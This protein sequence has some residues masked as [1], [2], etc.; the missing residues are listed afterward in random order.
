[1]TRKKGNLTITSQLEATERFRAKCEEEKMVTVQLVVPANRANDFK[2][3]A[4]KVRK[5]FRNSG[6]EEEVE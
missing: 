1:M 2:E 6:K 5:V 3:L 4:G